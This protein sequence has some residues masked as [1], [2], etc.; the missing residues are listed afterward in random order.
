MAP[1]LQACV[2]T[3]HGGT[4][5]SPYA[6]LNL[7]LS[8]GDDPQRVQANR[9]RLRHALG[10]EEVPLVHLAQVHGTRIWEA[11]DPAAREG[12]GWWTSAPGRVL[13]VG[14]AD[15]V[16]VF[17]WDVR[18]RRLALV[19]A[20]WRGTAAGVLAIALQM[21]AA[22]GSRPEDLRVALGPCIGPCCYPVDDTVA[23]RFPAIAVARRNG[24][25]HVDLRAANR[26]QAEAHG[27]LSGHIEAD[28]PCTGCDTATFFSHRK[29]G[30][31]TGRMWALAWLLAVVAL[32]GCSRAPEDP[33]SRAGQAIAVSRTQSAGR[34]LS[35]DALAGRHFASAD[36]DSAAE[37]L[38]AE[39][40]RAG[41]RSTAHADELFGTRP[42]VFVH[43]FSMTLYRLGSYNA[44]SVTRAGRET[45][46]RLGEDWMPLVFGRS[47]RVTA[48]IVPVS[49]R[50]GDPALAAS[51]LAGKIAVVEA[52]DLP[53]GSAGERLEARLYRAARMLGAR[54]AAAVVVGG[55][56]AMLQ[57][58]G[59]T[60]PEQLPPDLR[61]A[62][63][64]ARGAATNLLADRLSLA[65]QAQAWADAPEPTIP[66][67]LG[68][69]SWVEKLTPGDVLDLSVDLRPE[70]SLAENVLVGF[71]GQRHPEELVV[72][73]A[74]YDHTGVNAAGDVLNGADDNASG[75]V[76]L[77]GVAGALAQVHDSLQRSVLVV[78]FAA[79]RAGLQGSEALLHDLSSLA[80]S[81]ARPV[82]MLALRGVGRNGREPLLVVGGAGQPQLAALLERFDRAPLLGGDS[83]GLR[84]ASEETTPWSRLEALPSRGS[85]H[86]SFA[87]AGIPSVLLTDGLDPSLYGQP[88][89]D[90][91]LVDAAKVTRVAR[92]AFNATCAL[93]STTA[94]NAVPAASPGR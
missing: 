13:V 58:A 82:A 68:Q 92:L 14:V 7:S 75:A 18:T 80:G 66:V 78:F 64:S 26:V 86:L 53:P 52:R 9:A 19:H 25:A 69:S 84:L 42:A 33:L 36:A 57:S 46:V 6:A 4:S 43:S 35:S 10:L 16:P 89:D 23:A 94:G 12:D 73:G 40:R 2:T 70:V 3:R 30:P 71:R 79:G 8:V 83:L 62:V 60:F 15:C 22:A 74:G 50:P 28:P 27:V 31:K 55:P 24:A 48:P 67:L 5:S 41:I 72:I 45:S 54:G 21:F 32:A 38:I 37:F 20:G 61:A 87:R 29:S 85:E 76:A 91:S 34:W 63:A 1:W 56:V 11:Q 59:A 49:G 81:T 51:T 77:L 88:E 90:W 47:G 17:A 44:V 65:A 93:A 39:L